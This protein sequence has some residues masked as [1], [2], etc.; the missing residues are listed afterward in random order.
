MEPDYRNITSYK[1]GLPTIEDAF[2]KTGDF[3][4][5]DL[6]KKVVNVMANDLKDSYQ[7]LI[8]FSKVCYDYIDVLQEYNKNAPELNNLTKKVGGIFYDIPRWS[9]INHDNRTDFVTKDILKG[10]AYAISTGVVG[11]FVFP[12]LIPMQDQVAGSLGFLIG[13]VLGCIG[14]TAKMKKDAPKLDVKIAR[15]KANVH[16]IFMDEVDNYLKTRKHLID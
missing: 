10:V 2:I 7:K 8:C 11:A 9:Q 14:S 4:Q 5:E 6:E 12:L 16:D 13:G 1:L 15:E 3:T